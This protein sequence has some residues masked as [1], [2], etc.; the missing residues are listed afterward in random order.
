MKY[1]RL[2]A[3]GLAVSEVALGSWLTFGQG[4]DAAESERVVRR[5]FELGVNLFDSAD[6]YAGGEA[7][8]VLGRALAPLSRHR[9]VIATKCFWPMSDDPNDRGLSRKHLFESVHASLRRL[10][11]DYL[12]LHQC[13]R[14]DPDTPLEETVRAYGDLIHQGKVLYWGVS[15]WDEGLVARACRLADRLGV[16]RPI[17]NQPQYSLLVRHVER[18]LLAANARLGV[19]QIVWSPLAQGV[20]TGK[21][22]SGE[23]HAQRAPYLAGLLSEANLARVAR[24]KEARARARPH[25]GTA[26]AQFCLRRPEV[27]AV[28][29][30][31]TRVAQRGE[32]R[33]SGAALPSPVV[34]RLSV[35]PGVGAAQFAARERSAW[36]RSSPAPLAAAR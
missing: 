7:E 1:R 2:G 18:R 23:S 9:L 17:S 8:R 22:A 11:T 3:S 33:R 26:R 34:R 36:N 30:G 21:Y 31:A 16:P 24:L 20:L 29:H 5:A 6:A 27:A 12:D 28:D 13:H 35:L 15:E 19:S 10:G 14:A 25:A 32:R 4:V